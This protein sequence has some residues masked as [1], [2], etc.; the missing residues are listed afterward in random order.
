MDTIK[1][2]NRLLEVKLFE[3]GSVVVKQQKSELQTLKYLVL[4]CTAQELK[5]IVASKELQP[6]IY[7]QLVNQSFI[8]KNSDVKEVTYCGNFNNFKQYYD[9]VYQFPHRR[10]DI[11]EGKEPQ[12][13]LY[14]RSLQ[15][16]RDNMWLVNL[17][18]SAIKSWQS[19]IEK[20]GSNTGLIL[21]III[22]N[23]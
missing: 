20:A 10:I 5:E 23:N 11:K 9:L 8:T 21:K 15:Y 16:Q 7:E 22:K 4:P 3:K 18:N 17:C 13:R 2:K 14:T 1:E 12:F 19:V 6:F